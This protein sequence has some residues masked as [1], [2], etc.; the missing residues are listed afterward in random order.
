MKYEPALIQ[1]S[2]DGFN[3]MEQAYFRLKR[4]IIELKRPPSEQFTE[5]EVAEAW[6]LSKT[7]VR[8]A[9]ARLHRDG[10]VAP[11]PRA[12]YVVSAITLSDVSDLC[13]MRILL[14]SEAAALTAARGLSTSHRERLTALCMDDGYGQLA[15]PHL[16]ERLRA[17]YEFESIIANG[18]GNDRLA[19]TIVGVFDEIERVGRLAVLLS[20][21]M[22]PFRIEERKA[23]VDAIIARDPD[24]ARLAM[25][26]RTQSARREILDALTRSSEVNSVQ[27][28][29]P[30]ADAVVLPG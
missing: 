17:N 12:G 22:P 15:G 9:L 8:E 16:D 28:M 29:V 26:H 3:L 18:C 6:G 14:Q 5:Q 21:D 11:V 27:I 10:L 20:P 19:A 25:R 1:A 24:A 7:P 2:P 13:D 23:I 4:E 30:T